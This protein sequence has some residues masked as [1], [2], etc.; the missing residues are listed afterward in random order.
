[1]GLAMPAATWRRSGLVEAA[2]QHVSL[3]GMWDLY[4]NRVHP[5]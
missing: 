2:Q 1:M 4:G 3:L 5:K